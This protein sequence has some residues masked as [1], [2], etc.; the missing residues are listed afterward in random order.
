MKTVGNHLNPKER[1]FF[2]HRQS[3]KCGGNT[4]SGKAA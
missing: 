1:K 2:I 3:K 4:L